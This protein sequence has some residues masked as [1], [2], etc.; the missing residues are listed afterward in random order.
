MEL[1][2]KKKPIPPL[3]KRMQLLPIEHKKI[4]AETHF[5]IGGSGNFLVLEKE[6]EFL[7][8]DCFLSSVLPEIKKRIP[9]AFEPGA[10]RSLILSNFVEHRMEAV[11]EI[12]FAEIYAPDWGEAYDRE[13]DFSYN[14]IEEQESIE[15]LGLNVEFLAFG[16]PSFRTLTI[17][18]LDYHLS[19]LGDAFFN[20]YYPDM[21]K[22]LGLSVKDWIYNL[23]QIDKAY[24]ENSLFLPGEGEIGNKKMLK[25]FQDY[26]IQLEKKNDLSNLKSFSL[27][28]IPNYT[29]LEYNLEAVQ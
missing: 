10:K 17:D 12:A 26:L 27:K 11:S 20:G 24:A 7:F 1:F 19:Y 4:N 18:I 6:D 28:E 25:E 21:Q 3:R 29:S 13:I 23:K 16:G 15:W 5:F 8:V 9:Q 22:I 14:A 2:K